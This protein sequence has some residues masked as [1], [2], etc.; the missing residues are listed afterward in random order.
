MKICEKHNC[1]F[2]SL[3]WTTGGKVH[4]QFFCPICRKEYKALY[5]QNNREDILEQKSKYYQENKE[6]LDKKNYEYVQNNKEQITK[7]KANWFQDNK[8]KMAT[9][10]KDR[11]ATDISFRL[12]D[13]FSS[14][15]RQKLKRNRGS[16]SGKSILQFLS[17]SIQQ[18]KEHLEKQ[19][20]PW[21]NWNNYGKYNAKIWDDND[22]STWTWNIDHI[23]PQYDLSYVSMSD[24]NFQKCW[25]LENLRPLSAKQ[26]LVDGLTR[27]RHIGG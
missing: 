8:E 19:F 15:I 23:I 9:D 12:K 3:I 20:E 11:Y 14:S 1:E 7:Y 6:I 13:I 26:N 21:M 27:K 24:A 2:K 18:L 16:K 17:Y 10:R 4:T 22:L 25:A 5:Y